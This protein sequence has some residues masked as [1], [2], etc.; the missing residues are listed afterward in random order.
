MK[1][2]GFSF[3][4][5]AIKYDY[6]IVEALKSIIPLCDEVIVCV[7]QSEDK[8]L[9]IV[10]NIDPKITI[11]ET[12]WDDSLREGGKVLADETNKAFQNI[13]KKYDW[14]VYIQ[15]DE[16]LHEDGITEI[17]QKMAYHLNDD[18]IDGLLLPYKHF[19]GSYDYLGDATKWYRHE[20]RVIKNNKA[21]YSYRDAQGF[22]KNNNEK[23][24][25]KRTEAYMH[26][27]GWVKTPDK[28]QAKYESF[29][30]LWHNDEWIE[31]NIINADA[32]DYSSI[33][34]LSKFEGS[35]PKVMLNRIAQKNW[36]FSHDISKNSYSLK[37][38]FKIFVERYTGK[39]P[40]EYRNY[41]L[42]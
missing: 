11:I 5:N 19:Y 42:V 39:R 32:F 12:V 10:Q 36:E 23:L 40:G 17:R 21:I 9:E 24:K 37:D 13:P 25:V 1:V 34:S 30:K 35:H 18:N 14:A 15:G 22:R 16:I 8:T 3:I 6:P 29:N 38:K 28:M 26:H 33:K 41:K 4:R 20:I 31:K 2:C 27:Y 7:G